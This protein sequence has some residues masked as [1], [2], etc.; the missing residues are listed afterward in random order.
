MTVLPE[1]VATLPLYDRVAQLAAQN[2][3]LL[4]Q[5]DTMKRREKHY[6]RAILEMIDTPATSVASA[7]YT[8]GQW[9]VVMTDGRVWR[10]VEKLIS[11]EHEHRYHEQWISRPAVPGSRAAIA[12]ALDDEEPVAPLH[13]LPGRMAS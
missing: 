12:E 8:N 3:E 6:A 10:R 11:N 13:L 5:L 7:K 4:D 9:E 2:R 1:N